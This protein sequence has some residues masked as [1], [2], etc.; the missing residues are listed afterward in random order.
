K[1]DGSIQKVSVSKAKSDVPPA[2]HS[3]KNVAESPKAKP[4]VHSQPKNDAHI[5]NNEIVVEKDE[6]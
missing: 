2:N 4:E 5:E 3:D 1:A 6:K